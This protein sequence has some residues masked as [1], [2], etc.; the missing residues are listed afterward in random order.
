M[1]ITFTNSAQQ[2]TYQKVVDYL[3]NSSLFKDSIQTKVDLPKFLLTYS[4]AQVEVDILAW[5]VHPWDT[6][7]LA[8]VRVCSCVT[9]GT[10]VDSE[11]MQYL[12]RENSRMRFGAFQLSE[13]ARVLFA[14][15]IL[16]GE[17]MDLMELQTCILAV[18]TIAHTYD[19]IIIEKFGGQRE[20]GRLV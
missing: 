13:S 6:R 1:P 12:L 15:S 11:L 7:E 20:T 2:I 9:V 16:G 19:D 5:E 4:S 10:R 3:T 8:I 17:N 18:V 14:D